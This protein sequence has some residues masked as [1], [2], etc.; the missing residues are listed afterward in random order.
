MGFPNLTRPF[1]YDPE[2]RA[3]HAVHDPVRQRVFGNRLRKQMKSPAV[4]IVAIMI[5]A[6]CAS[7]NNATSTAA[8]PAPAE[9]TWAFTASLPGQSAEGELVIE[10]DTVFVQN[11]AYC[12]LSYLTP[13]EVRVVCRST[14]AMTADSRFQAQPVAILTFDRRNPT[15]STWT[16]S[17]P[18]RR[19]REVCARTEIRNG[20]EVCV[21]R[22]MEPYEVSERRTGRV[23]VRRVP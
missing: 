7:A 14:M 5:L 2:W 1:D 11:A 10:H 4:S 18:V 15:S 12:G 20:R 19:T 13:G 8:A 21:S 3:F 22:K 6:A 17:V 9:G 16:M 23:T